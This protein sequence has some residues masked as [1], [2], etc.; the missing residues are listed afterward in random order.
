MIRIPGMTKKSSLFNVLTPA[1]PEKQGGADCTNLI[2]C[3]TFRETLPPLIS[4]EVPT[5]GGVIFVK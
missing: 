1:L 5:G 4:G 2:D 3:H